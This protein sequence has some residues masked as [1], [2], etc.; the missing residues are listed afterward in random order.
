M[1]DEADRHEQ[2]GDDQHAAAGV[3][4]ARLLEC[5]DVH[6]THAEGALVGSGSG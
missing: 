2:A 5:A 4:G 3:G 6:T 1:K